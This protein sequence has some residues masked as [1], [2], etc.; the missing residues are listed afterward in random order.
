MWPDRLSSDKWLHNPQCRPPVG[1]WRQGTAAWCPAWRCTGPATRGGSDWWAPPQT[2]R[3]EAPRSRTSPLCG[4]SLSA[5]CSLLSCRGRQTRKN[6]SYGDACPLLEGNH[7]KVWVQFSLNAFNQCERVGVYS[8][9][10]VLPQCERV[11]ALQF[12]GGVSDQKGAI[13]SVAQLLIH[14]LSANTIT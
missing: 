2:G 8:N 1:I 12:T 4:K 13:G 9:S 3:W 14:F 5:C 10:A 11:L 6:R 7:S